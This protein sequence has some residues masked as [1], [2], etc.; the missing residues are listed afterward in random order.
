LYVGK[1]PKALRGAAERFSAL[2][3]AEAEAVTEAP[4]V[5]VS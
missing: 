2:L 5:A 1:V 3:L 4:G